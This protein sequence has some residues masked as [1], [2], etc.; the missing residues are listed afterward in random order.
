MDLKESATEKKKA[1]RDHSL[2]WEAR[3]G[4]ARNV[5]ETRWR[6]E[7]NVAGDRVTS[8]RG[9]WKL[10]EAWQ[11]GREQENALAITLAVLKIATL[12][13]ADRLCAC[14]C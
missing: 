9:F 2:E 14:G 3:P 4:D 13:G 7:I 10:P 1:R 5:D 8:A 12:A 6:V 11:R